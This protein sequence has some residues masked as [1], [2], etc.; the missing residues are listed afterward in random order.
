MSS[1]R[2]IVENKV[3]KNLKKKIPENTELDN[4]KTNKIINSVLNSYIKY[5]NKKINIYHK[6]H[7]EIHD[8]IDYC[9]K[10]VLFD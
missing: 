6:E 1:A 2:E 5:Q 10:F 8:N 4:T 9:E 7:I 3:V